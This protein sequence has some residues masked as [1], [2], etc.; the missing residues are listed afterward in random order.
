MFKTTKAKVIGLALVGT[1]VLAGAVYATTA[2]AVGGASAAPATAQAVQTTTDPQQLRSTILEMLRDRMG[3][4]GPQAEQFADQMI[5]RLQNTNAGYDLQDMINWCTQFLTTDANGSGSTNGG[6]GMMGGNSSYDG[7]WG[8]MYGYGATTP[9]TSPTDQPN[10]GGNTPVLPG[11]Q[12]GGSSYYPGGMMNGTNPVNGSSSTNSGWGMMYGNG[13]GNGATTPST[14]T[15]PPGGVTPNGPQNGGSSYYPGGM[16][17][18]TGPANGTNSVNGTDSTNGGFGMMN[19]VT[20]PQAGP[21]NPG[22]SAA[23]STPGPQGSGSG[24]TPGGM[25]GGGMMGTAGLR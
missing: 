24:F 9:S 6:W 16:M 4:T 17:Y 5:A 8:M 21:S 20:I 25:M 1:V 13:S 11:Q 15:S 10:P 2:L 23:P 22:G 14:Q 18:G 7:G 3:L 12:N 19:G